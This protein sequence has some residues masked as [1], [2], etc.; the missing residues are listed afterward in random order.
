MPVAPAGPRPSASG[1]QMADTEFK[2]TAYSY[3]MEIFRVFS[4]VWQIFL[5]KSRDQWLF[6]EVRELLVFL[7]LP[8]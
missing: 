5:D 6:H 2:A 7:R 8:V 1:D 4:H 3:R